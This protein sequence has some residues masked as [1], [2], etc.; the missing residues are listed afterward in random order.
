MNIYRK[1]NVKCFKR[2]KKN[3]EW[4]KSTYKEICN[5][6][7]GSSSKKCNK[8]VKFL[9]R[10][11][12]FCENIFRDYTVSARDMQRQHYS[13]NSFRVSVRYMNVFYFYSFL[14]FIINFLN[15]F[16]WVRKFLYFVWLWAWSAFISFE[17]VSVNIG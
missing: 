12:A 6:H 1:K 5:T 7:P 10:T 13:A 4:N 2:N 11:W 14:I 3:K 16:K 17:C 9:I 8:K 15:F